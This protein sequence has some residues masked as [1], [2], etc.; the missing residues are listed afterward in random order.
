VNWKRVSHVLEYGAVGFMARA[1]RILPLGWALAFGAFLGW[2]A[3]DIFRVRRRVALD[4]LRHALGPETSE[5]ERV[6]IGRRSYMNFGRFVV[7]FS[8]F[9]LLSKKTLQERVTHRGMEHLDGAFAGGR[10]VILLASHFG[11][12]ELQGVSFAIL[13]YPMHFLVGEQHNRAVDDLM[14]HLRRGTGVGIIPKGYALRGVIQALRKNEMVGLLGDQDARRRGVFVEFFGRP[15]STPRGPASFALKTGALIVPSFI[16]RKKA[17]RHEVV[18]E[19]PI[20]AVPSGDR[21][22]DIRRVTQAHVRV[23]ER[24][25]R[26]HPDHWFWPHRRWKTRPPHTSRDA[27]RESTG[28][29]A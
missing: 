4:N 7:E 28:A 5:G 6:A 29:G 15:A 20:E 11:S 17:G 1:A 25:V 26:A 21:E 14:N 2:L 12:W 24:Y 9:P 8:R 23:L 18:V 16:I 27:S 13:G 3:W 22:A 19:T 10:G